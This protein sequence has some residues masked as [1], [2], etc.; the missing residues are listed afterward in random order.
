MSSSTYL[1]YTYVYTCT[2]VRISDKPKTHWLASSV[3]VLV[4]A[5]VLV[6]VLVLLG[7]VRTRM[8]PI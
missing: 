3:V 8:M 1:K 4:V 6:L 2:Y 5:L 7:R